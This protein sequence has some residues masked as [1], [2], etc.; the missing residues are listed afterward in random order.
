MN[1][2]FDREE[3][4]QGFGIVW[5]KGKFVINAKLLEW[6]YRGVPRECLPGFRI[7]LERFPEHT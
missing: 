3:S 7:G 6:I 1:G 5:F 2:R 4:L